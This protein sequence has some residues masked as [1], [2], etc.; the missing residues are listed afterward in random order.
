[1]A[2]LL[3]PRI[4]ATELARNLASAI[5]QVRVSRSRLII[6]RGNQDVAQL[7][8]VISNGATLADLDRLLKRNILSQAEKRAFSEDLRTIR[9]AAA[10]P[11]SPWD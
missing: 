10:L 6:T 8:P 3:T 4:S 9:E 7:V 11:K 1:M 5:D 2:N